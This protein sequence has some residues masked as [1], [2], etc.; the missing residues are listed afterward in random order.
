MP[1]I[2][3]QT[4]WL[5]SLC[6]PL[7]A[8]LEVRRELMNALPHA[9]HSCIPSPFALATCLGTLLL[10]V[11]W[12]AL[13]SAQIKPRIVVGVD[14]SG[15]MIWDLSGKTTYGDGVGRRALPEDP[16]ESVRD[17]VYYGCGTTAGLDRD[18][19]GFPNDSRMAIAKDAIR[20]LVLGYGDVD[21]SLAKFRQ[22]HALNKRC[23][24]YNGSDKCDLQA[25]GNPQC[26]TGAV[27][28]VGCVDAVPLLCRPGLSTTPSLRRL[29]AGN[30]TACV[31]YGFDVDS[32]NEEQSCLG[33]D[34]LV[35]FTGLGAFEQL[36]NR[37]ALLR[38]IDQVETHFDPD[39]SAGDF[40]RHASGGD[41]ELRPGGSTP[42]G[43]LV[44]ASGQYALRVR[45]D[46]TSAACRQYST[47]L[48]TDGVESCDNNPEQR[49]FELAYPQQGDCDP[50]K[51]PNTAPAIHTYIVGIS[52]V[53]S[54]RAALDRIAACGGTARA[55][56]TSSAS[57]L[58]AA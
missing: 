57:Q 8:A 52:I 40:C 36:D 37:P 51:L 46:D 28:N 56:F 1:P 18:C 31:N 23:L 54:D 35:G 16:A 15:S 22:I 6:P 14:T 19:D 11:S 41:C 42:L 38:W 17:G 7:R 29:A 49:A 45:A 30:S 44:E 24:T 43:A 34:V 47:I 33:A 48:L 39:I 27:D 12:H 32:R 20:K 21:W 55:Y 5:C 26:N 2:A 58:S 25:Y 4:I 9:R 50:D 13:A 53:D 10:V 3:A